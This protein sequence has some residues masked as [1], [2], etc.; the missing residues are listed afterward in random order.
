VADLRKIPLCRSEFLQD[1]TIKLGVY[2]KHR[3]PGWRGFLTASRDVCEH[4]GENLERLAIWI[5]TYD[6]VRTNLV[7]WEN[8]TIWIE[9]DLLA[10]DHHT[11]EYTVGFYPEFKKVKYAG[12]LD[13]FDSTIALSTRLCYGES[14]TI[15]LKKIWKYTGKASI[16]GHLPR[17]KPSTRS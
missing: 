1:F 5:Q 13:A 14:P 15:T 16:T 2:M 11:A 4:E 3:K 9:I 8:E 10:A 17:K 7:L 12:M 6:Y